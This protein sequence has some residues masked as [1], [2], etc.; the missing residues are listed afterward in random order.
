MKI[1]CVYVLVN[2]VNGKSYLGS[3]TDLDKRI[4]SHKSALFN[5]THRNKGLLKDSLKYNV[6]DFKYAV[7]EYLSEEDDMYAREKIWLEMASKSPELYYNESFD[8]YGGGADTT[9]K[10][11][12]ILD[13]SGNI[14]ESHESILDATNSEL[15]MYKSD[16]VLVN[17]NRF[18]VRG[19][20]WVVTKDFYERRW[21]KIEGWIESRRKAEM[22][23][24]DREA[25]ELLK[26][27][28]KIEFVIDGKTYRV[29]TYKEAGDII[30]L[31][32]ERV[33]Q[34]VKD[35]PTGRLGLRKL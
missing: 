25:K 13:L 1:K 4:R 10:A 16:N 3:T 30:G 24:L 23:K 28:P 35:N 18:L 26:K 20:Y 17:T 19:S 34:I 29:R 9:K 15:I 31:S 8:P 2:K 32:S 12:Y 21:N 27:A 7:V 5:K 14:L 6:E 33:R 11:C 22:S